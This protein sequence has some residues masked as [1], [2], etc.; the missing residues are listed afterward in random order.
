MLFLFALLAPFCQDAREIGAI[1]HHPELQDALGNGASIVSIEHVD[2]SYIVSTRDTS[3]Q[4]DVEY[5]P[6]RHPGPAHFILHFHDPVAC[7]P[8]E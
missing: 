7:N 8:Q 2:R 1:M 3:I 5:I 4:I 6:R